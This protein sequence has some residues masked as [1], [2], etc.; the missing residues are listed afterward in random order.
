MS[1]TRDFPTIE[2]VLREHRW[3]DQI[4]HIRFC[5]TK[6]ARSG[7]DRYQVA[8]TKQQKIARLHW[9]E[10]THQ[11]ARGFVHPASH[12]IA[13]TGWSGGGCD[14]N[15]SRLDVEQTAEAKGDGVLVLQ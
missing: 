3:Q 4:Q 1:E 8:I 5:R 11:R 2:P 13:G 9:R 10:E 15:A 7:D 12:Y 14:Q 6:A